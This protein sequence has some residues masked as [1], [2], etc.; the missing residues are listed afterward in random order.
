MNEPGI[1]RKRRKSKRHDKSV[2]RE[3]RV[4]ILIGILFLFGVFL[5]FEQMEIKTIVFKGIV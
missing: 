3:F 1:E 5:L 2:I 4:E